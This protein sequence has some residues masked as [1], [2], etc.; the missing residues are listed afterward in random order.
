[1]GVEEVVK[2]RWGVLQRIGDVK[3][4]GRLVRHLER[5]LVCRDLAERGR[6]A[7]RVTGEE[8][9]GRVGEVLALPRHGEL[10]ERRDD[11]RQYSERYRDD[12]DDRAPAPTITI[13]SAAPIERAN[14]N[15][16]AAIP[17]PGAK[18][19]PTK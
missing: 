8:R 6:E 16:S 2:E 19:S 15:G 5:L 11:R 9:A 12:R 4:C 7:R 17:P 3:G 10:D 1:M 14:A 18:Y 13:A